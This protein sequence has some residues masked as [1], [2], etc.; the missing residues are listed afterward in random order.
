MGPGTTTLIFTATGPTLSFG[1]FLVCPDGGK[2]GFGAVE[3]SQLP[4]PD[5]SGYMSSFWRLKADGILQLLATDIGCDPASVDCDL[6]TGDIYCPHAY[7]IARFYWWATHFV[8]LPV[9]LE[10][11]GP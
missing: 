7:G 11:F 1:L 10:D 4:N 3:A 6:L 2:Y 8:H 9:A 5:G